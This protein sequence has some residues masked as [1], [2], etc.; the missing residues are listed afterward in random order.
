MP[1]E[2]NINGSFE[3]GCL[4][5]D[6]IVA[7]DNSVFWVADD[8]T[9]RRL[10]GI[11]PQRVS[12]HAIEQALVSAT[13]LEAFSYEQEG[14]FFY[15]L[16]ATE[17]TWVLDVATGEWAERSS[18]GCKCW[19]PRY[20]AQFAGKELVADASSNKVGYFD[21][22]TFEDW[23]S[24]QRM[25]WTYQPVYAEGQRAFHDR[26]EVVMETGTGATTGQGSDPKIMLQKSDD[27]GNTWQSMP[28]KSIGPLGERQA[29][30]VWHNLGSARQR[31]YRCAVSD[32]VAVTVTDTLLEVRG[33][34]L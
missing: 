31:V 24:T 22:D 23:G 17:G 10:E 11:T 18:Y 28:D 9:V 5:G 15:V 14:H 13:N 27:G 25:E 29:R 33:G 3:V 34:R 16:G 19:K 4:D 8:Y 1:F 20:H 21:F 7:L 2:R 30:A 12:T 6:T 26:F 32:P